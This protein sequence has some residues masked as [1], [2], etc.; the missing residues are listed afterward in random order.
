MNQGDNNYTK[1]KW[2]Y[3]ERDIGF[4]SQPCWNASVNQLFFPVT[5]GTLVMILQQGTVGGSPG[6]RVL[7]HKFL[8]WVFIPELDLEY[9]SCDTSEPACS[10][11]PYLTHYIVNI[12]KLC[13]S[14]EISVCSK[15]AIISVPI[16]C[17]PLVLRVEPRAFALSYVSSAAYFSSWD[18]MT[19]SQ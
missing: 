17:F 14:C 3:V 10:W 6:A 13:I 7:T 8:A 5:L 16:L 15:N 19:Q 2:A 4:S 11:Y 18:G 9:L 12:A 1:C